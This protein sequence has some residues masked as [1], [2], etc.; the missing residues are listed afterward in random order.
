MNDETS[1]ANAFDVW[2]WVTNQTHKQNF[3]RGEVPT[4]SPAPAAIDRPASPM[5]VSDPISATIC[6][7]TSAA[8]DQERLTY[9]T[10]RSLGLRQEMAVEK[11]GIRLRVAADLEAALPPESMIATAVRRGR[12][13]PQARGQAANINMALSETGLILLSWL[14]GMEPMDYSMIRQIFFRDEPQR[15]RLPDKV[16]YWRRIAESLPPALSVHV[17]I[18][19]KHLTPV[20]IS[21]MTAL[22]P[23]VK[24]V[25]DPRIGERPVISLFPRNAQN[26]VVSARL[27]AVARSYCLAIDALVQFVNTGGRDAG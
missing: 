11:T 2:R 27:T 23:A 15:H 17:R 3:R 5:A 18:G 9:L 12:Q 19:A 22:A 10:V 20:E 25:P 14:R 4:P 16:I 1:S 7:P 21:H 24:L 6:D 13:G 8:N 26:L